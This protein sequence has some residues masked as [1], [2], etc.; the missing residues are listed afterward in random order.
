MRENK[1]R[2]LTGYDNKGRVVWWEGTINRAIQ[3]ALAEI[4][5]HAGGD[6]SAYIF[7]KAIFN[8]IK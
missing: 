7:A 6:S 5:E 1:I 2:F 3:I 8:E 4:F